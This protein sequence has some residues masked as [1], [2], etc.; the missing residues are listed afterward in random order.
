MMGVPKPYLAPLIKSCILPVQSQGYASKHRRASCPNR[1]AAAI[2][3]IRCNRNTCCGDFPPPW[4][5]K[6][7][8]GRGGLDGRLHAGPSWALP[9]QKKGLRQRQS[10]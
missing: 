3:S 9:A 6:R 7:C 2:R 5:H 8:S 10:V 1:L 4:S